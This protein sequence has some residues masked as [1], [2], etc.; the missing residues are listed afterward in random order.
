MKERKIARIIKGR[1]GSDGAGVK[2]IRLFSHAEAKDLDPFLM[3]DAFDSVDPEDYENGFPW[4]PHRGIETITYLIEGN[5]EHQDSLGNTGVLNSGDGQWMTAVSGII[6]NEMPKASGRMRGFQLWLNLPKRD[7]MT[8]SSYGDI[9]SHEIP[10][11]PVGKNKVR[12]VAGL[13]DGI[14]GAFTGKYVELQFLDIDLIKNDEI[15][16][17]TEPNNTVFAYVLEGDVRFS[18]SKHAIAQKNVVLFDSGNTLT[19]EAIS[20][21]A[22]IL[23]FNAPPLNEPVAWAGPIVMNT[24]DELRLA[25]AQLQRGTFVQPN[26]Q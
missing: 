1:E 12:I 11:I 25:F 5:I 20:D 3:M 24:E 8:Q 14:K 21:H 17:K 9:K 23:I 15:V 6:H 26:S 4:H 2:L 22:R 13:F 7:K 16:I 10:E 19:T 18:K